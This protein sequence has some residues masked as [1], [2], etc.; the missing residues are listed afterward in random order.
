MIIWLL[1]E[2]LVFILSYF[3]RFSAGTSNYGSTV[4]QNAKKITFVSRL[5]EDFT[6][7]ELYG[8]PLLFYANAQL[9]YNRLLWLVCEISS[10]PRIPSLLYF[11]VQA[12]DLHIPMTHSL[13]L[14]SN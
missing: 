12:R 14:T 11:E 8:V 4:L 1:H 5:Y 6:F 9:I 7:N 13:V 10:H 2:S 3:T